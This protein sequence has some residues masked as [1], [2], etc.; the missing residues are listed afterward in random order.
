MDNFLI[1]NIALDI[2]CLILS[3]IPIIYLGNDHRWHQKLNRYFLGV[4]VSNGLMIIGDLGDW[5]FRDITTPLMMTAAILLVVLYYVSSA[6]VLYFFA[7][8]IDEYLKLTH[9]VRTIFLRSITLLCGVQIFFALI[10][11]LTGAIFTITAAGYQRGSLFLI[12]AGSAVLLFV[13]YL[14]GRT[15]SKKAHPP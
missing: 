15:E 9:P 14:A 1:A 12:P 6:F 8:Y 2:F 11:P 10:S 4:S 5:C 3:L 13:V 7:R